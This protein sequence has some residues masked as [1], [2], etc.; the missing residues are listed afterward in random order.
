MVFMYLFLAL[1]ITLVWR[2]V[3][4]SRRMHRVM[5]EHERE[6][7]AWIQEREAAENFRPAFDLGK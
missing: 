1:M 7:N 6:L 3:A 4:R 5:S 2:D